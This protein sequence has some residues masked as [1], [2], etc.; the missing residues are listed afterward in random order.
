MKNV[1]KLRVE[2]SRIDDLFRLLSESRPDDE[3]VCMANVVREINGNKVGF[4]VFEGFY[5]R[6]QRT[7]TGSAFIYQT[8]SDSSEIIIVGSGGATALGIT[9]GAQTDIENKISDIILKHAQ[10]I[11]MKG[12]KIE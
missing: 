1:K 6:T 11:G 5:L 7:V 12:Y 10:E 3:N 2:G 8:G 4:F 9:W